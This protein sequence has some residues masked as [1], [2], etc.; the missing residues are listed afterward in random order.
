MT[1]NIQAMRSSSIYS[2]LATPIV[3]HVSLITH[4][5]ELS[6]GQV[7]REME[8]LYLQPKRHY[9][10]TLYF[11]E[12]GELRNYVMLRRFPRLGELSC[13]VGE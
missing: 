12:R 6:L 1:E 4:R 9:A 11:V 2:P 5:L 8:Y 13:I 3:I 7:R 10:F